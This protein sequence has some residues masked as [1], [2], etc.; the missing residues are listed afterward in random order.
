MSLI[1]WVQVDEMELPVH[2]MT[3]EECKER[4]KQLYE[5]EIKVK[6]V[7]TLRTFTNGINAK[8]LNRPT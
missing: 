2:G 5:G 8:Q 4:A 7:Q 1:M 6:S 3:E